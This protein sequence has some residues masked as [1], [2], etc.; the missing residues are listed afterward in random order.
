[1]CGAS[2]TPKRKKTEMIIEN[3]KG[4]DFEPHPEGINPAVCIDV[5]DCGIMESNFQ[6]VKKMVH[7]LKLVF[8]SE[9]V[10]EKG[11]RCTIQKM[12]TASLYPKSTLANMLG[13][14]RG[15]PVAE[16][17]KIDLDD[18]IGASCTLVIGHK[19][20]ADG[21]KVYANIDAISKPT[22][23]VIPSGTYD[24]LAARQRFADWKA[25]N[26]LPPMPMTLP[27]PKAAKDNGEGSDLGP[28]TAAPAPA[29]SAAPPP[30]RPL[31]AAPVA[32]VAVAPAPAPVAAPVAGSVELPAEAGDCDVPF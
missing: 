28:Q 32:P 15:R 23:K 3:V 7:K 1:M 20:S 18:L 21:T 4:G 25:K 13:K 16:G 27:K 19:P 26:N 9:A 2:R 5:M 6:G 31:P 30:Y 11:V 24:A 12:V 8:E 22:K 17:E 14:W 10:T 29:R